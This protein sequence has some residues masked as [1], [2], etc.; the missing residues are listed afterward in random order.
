MRQETRAGRE[1]RKQDFIL[2]V[3]DLLAAKGW[4]Q[5]DLAR[6]AGV[7]PD[8]ISKYLSGISLPRI[9]HARRIAEALQVPVRELALRYD[10]PE[11]NQVSLQLDGE[12]ALLDVRALRLRVE[13]AMR[14][15]ADLNEARASLE[16]N[17]PPEGE[18]P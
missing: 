2:R 17:L 10:A 16:R 7:G 11:A 13:D 8:R 15:A 5:S 4:S 9:E 14:I 1:K 12:T 18:E 6:A 3:R